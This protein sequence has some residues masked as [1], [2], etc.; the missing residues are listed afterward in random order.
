MI[1]PDGFVSEIVPQQATSGDVGAGGAEVT[2]TGVLGAYIAV[3]PELSTLLSET[4]TTRMLPDEAV[5][6]AGMLLPLKLLI[7]TVPSNN[8]T[9]SYPDSVANAEKLRVGLKPL[10]THSQFVLGA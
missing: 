4:N 7:W 10:M 3:N 5:T 9:K 6:A 8:F 1:D 2:D